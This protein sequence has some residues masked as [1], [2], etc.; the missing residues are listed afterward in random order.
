MNDVWSRTLRRAKRMINKQ[1]FQTWISSMNC[2]GYKKGVLH[3]SVGSDS[4]RDWV[5]AN[6]LSYIRVAASAACN[7][8]VTVEIKVQDANKPRLVVPVKKS[9]RHSRAVEHP[10]A[11]VAQHPTNGNLALAFDGFV[12]GECNEFAYSACQ[13]VARQPASEFNPLYIYGQHGVGKTHLLC[14]TTN[15][16]RKT[17]SELS[18]LYQTAE[19][20]TNEFFESIATKQTAGFRARYRTQDVLLID[21]VQFVQS[22]ASTQEALFHTINALQERGR[23]VVISSDRLPEELF[24]V[25]PK[26]IER[27]SSGLVIDVAPPEFRMKIRIL[28]KKAELLDM[29]LLD[30]VA[31][32]IAEM[33]CPSVRQLES[34]LTKLKGYS[35]LKTAP[36]SLEIAEAVLG[37]NGSGKKELTVEA[38]QDKVAS[39]FGI[40]VSKL[41]SRDR[42]RSIVRA[43]QVAMFLSRDMLG[44]SYPSIG[45]KFSGMCHAA[46]IHSYKLI[47]AKMIADPAFHCLIET[48]K[49][50][51]GA[52]RQQSAIQRH[53]DM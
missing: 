35:E 28:R 32:Y 37:R 38:I 39:Y 2:E 21:D 26:L 46:V 31:T 10:S 40:G 52:L 47:R 45:K 13:S 6:Y 29:E 7:R 15:S 11:I 34:M 18:V 14:A 8:E 27:F 51:L 16:L 49:R 22:K 33:S 5:M 41:V 25:K 42:T 36:I 24:S 50:E 30:E 20:F 1:S 19:D 12:P 23:Q 17:H 4:H 3:L 44:D 53:L 9:S 43:R 48:L